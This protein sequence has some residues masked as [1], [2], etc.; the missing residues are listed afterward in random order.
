MDNFNLKGKVA[1][2]TGGAGHLGTAISEG[3]VH[4]NATVYIA[5]R[6]ENKC[7][8]IA[9]SLKKIFKVEVESIR[10]D[11]SRMD[12]IISCYNKVMDNAGRIDILVNNAY[13]GAGGKLEDISEDNWMKGIDGT[14]NGVFRC[15][16]ENIP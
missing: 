13:F 12:S 7:R 4:A 14:I 8:D 16:P 6:D 2:V 1:I 10:L 15:T 11:I 9:S 3:L 5:S